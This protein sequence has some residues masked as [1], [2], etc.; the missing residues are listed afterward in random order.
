MQDEGVFN[1]LVLHMRLVFEIQNIIKPQLEISNII[2]PQYLR[3]P[4]DAIYL[5]F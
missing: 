5:N 1:I 3:T 2:K 4:L